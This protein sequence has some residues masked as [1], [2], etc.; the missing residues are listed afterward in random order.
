MW[1]VTWMAFVTLWISAAGGVA[2]GAAGL[3]PVQGD[4]P[5]RAPAKVE[6]RD[7]YDVPHRWEF[8][9]TNVVVV[10]IADRDGSMQVDGWVSALKARYAGKLEWRGLAQVGGIPEFWRGR[11]RRKFQ[12]T[13]RYPVLLDWTGRECAA[14]GYVPGVANLL[15]IEPG[16]K[17]EHRVSGE[18]TTTNL[19]TA[20]AAI[21]RVLAAVAGAASSSA[22]AKGTG[23]AA[24]VAAAAGPPK[25]RTI[26]LVVG[27]AP[28]SDSR[29]VPAPPE[30]R[31]AVRIK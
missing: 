9:G 28:G 24:A 31:G 2:E 12:E 3:A 10:T 22:A 19:A 18:A 17:I 4:R 11:I 6:L 13:R 15:V 30:S 23:A 5:Q 26:P 14:F 20:T 16:G 21:D 1:R 8:P 25:T 29:D 27:G 7:Q